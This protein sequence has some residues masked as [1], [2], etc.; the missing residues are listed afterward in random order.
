MLHQVNDALVDDFKLIESYSFFNLEA[1]WVRRLKID[2][3]FPNN[4]WNGH[5]F[6]TDPPI[7]ASSSLFPPLHRSLTIH[8]ENAKSFLKSHLF[9]VV[10]SRLW[11]KHPI[12]IL[13]TLNHSKIKAALNAYLS[14]IHVLQ[15]TNTLILEERAFEPASNL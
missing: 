1:L 11:N 7:V 12:N 15:L 3:N 2:L 9:L 5:S 13:C 6:S 4:L 10:Y 14:S 8:T